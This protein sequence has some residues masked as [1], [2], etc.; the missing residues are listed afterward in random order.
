MGAGWNEERVD[1]S[2][3]RL[4]SI[5]ADA[6]VAALRASVRGGSSLVRAFEELR[7]APF[8]V[9]ELTRF[10][11][12]MAVRSRCRNRRH[13][14]RRERLGA[15]LHAVCALSLLLGCETSR[16]LDA[17]AASLKRQRLMDDLRSNAYAMPQATARLLMAL[18][19][20]TVALGEGMGA[21]PV[22]FLLGDGRGWACLG[23][24]GCCYAVGLVWIRAL[25][26]REGG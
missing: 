18:P 6:F 19:A 20:L 15:E 10:R 13:S 2:T 24:A 22:R 5:S 1:D 16:C 7:G 9:P 3:S 14:E 12:D 8:A 21:H 25:L 4:P 11:I 26:R 17:V 23:F